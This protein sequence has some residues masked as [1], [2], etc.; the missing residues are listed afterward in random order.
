MI[1]DLLVIGGGPGGYSAAIRAAQLGASVTLVEKERV[2]GTCL[3][4][5]CIPTK[6]FYKNAQVLHTLKNAGEFGIDV[7]GYSFDLAKMQEQKQKIITQLAVGVERLLQANKIELITGKAS[8]D[9]TNTVSVD[10]GEKRIKAKN[11]LIATGSVPA[12][13]PISGLELPGVMN[14]EEIL[15][16]EKLPQTV[17]IIGGG[18]IGI[19]F[20]GILNAM[21]VSVTVLELL[22]GILTGFDSEIVKRMTMGLKRKGIRLETEVKVE[23]IKRNGTQLCLLV[24]RDKEKI[25]LDVETVLVSTGRKANLDGLNLN[26]VG[27]PC[28]KNGIIV[29]D[30]YMTVVPGIYAIGDVIG[31]QMLAHLAVEEGKAAVE[32]M[33]GYEKRVNYQVVPACVFAFPEMAGVGLTEEQVQEMGVPYLTSKFLFGANGKALTMREGEGLV[34][35]IARKDTQ[36]LLGIHIMGPH[37]SDLI[38]EGALAI[39]HNM[40]TGEFGKTIHA[41]PTLAEALLEAV[42]GL[43][44]KAIHMFRKY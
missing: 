4:K 39:E 40:T 7:S 29:N 11:I 34:K 30:E 36:E 20:A 2:G 27:V 18:V 22:P 44:N 17:A 13:P 28:D 16:I 25:A 42:E 32:K 31:G 12:E 43:H 24:K 1:R 3:N 10:N 9:N 26:A 14:S 35:V 5:G 38:H 37:A 33:M 6:T 21:G 8:F 23:E 41:H 15:E 19:E